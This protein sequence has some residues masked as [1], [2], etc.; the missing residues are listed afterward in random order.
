MGYFF[1]A[2]DGVARSD[3]LEQIHLEF[4]AIRCKLL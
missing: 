3:D 2:P 1:C 4:T